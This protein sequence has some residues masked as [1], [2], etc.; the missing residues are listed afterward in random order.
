MDAPY[1]FDE[2]GPD[3][4]SVLLERCIGAA[5]VFDLPVEKCIT[6]FELLKLQWQ[7]VERALFKTRSSGL[8]EG[9]FDTEFAYLSEEAAQYL[10]NLG[11]RLVGTDAPSVDAF[12]ST[13]FPSH[14]ILL[15][16][17]IAILEGV[18]LGQ[19]PPGDYELI[20]LPL[21]LAGLDGSPVRA[22]LRAA[23]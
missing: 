9:R 12:G 23:P 18:R 19:V 21:R 5:R 7:G 13:T 20:S 4:A 6:A 15:S 11:L 2:S 17:D 3:I 1:H 16:H 8:A 14:N 10:A 22:I